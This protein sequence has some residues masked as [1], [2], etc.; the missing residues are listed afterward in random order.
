MKNKRTLLDFTRCGIAEEVA[1][2]QIS[3]QTLRMGSLFSMQI[4]MR[5]SHLATSLPGYEAVSQ[6][7][8]TVHGMIR[9]SVI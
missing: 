3:M 9:M 1:W 6:I 2:W 5:I 8:G 4:D 7:M